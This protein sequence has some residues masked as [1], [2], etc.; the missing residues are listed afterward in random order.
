MNDSANFC[1]LYDCH[2]DDNML[3]YLKKNEW[4]FK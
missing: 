4:D 1:K 3:D 2:I